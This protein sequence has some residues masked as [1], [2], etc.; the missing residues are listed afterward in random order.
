MNNYNIMFICHELY[1]SNPAALLQVCHMSDVCAILAVSIMPASWEVLCRWPSH[2]SLLVSQTP[3]PAATHHQLRHCETQLSYPWK[4]HACKANNNYFLYIFY[5]LLYVYGVF[6]IVLYRTIVTVYTSIIFLYNYQLQM[7][8]I[9]H[10]LPVGCVSPAR[11]K[12]MLK[13]SEV[14]N[15]K[16]TV[17]Q[18]S[19]FGT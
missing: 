2:L 3:S 16:G 11:G 19:I 8:Q 5:F 12:N 6:S 1:V 17:L 14:S 7:H 4:L 18:Y 10:L 15:V 9:I 13:N